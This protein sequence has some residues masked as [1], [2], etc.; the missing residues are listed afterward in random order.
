MPETDRT[1]Q[2]S[3][4]AYYDVHQLP[5]DGEAVQRKWLSVMADIEA[6]RFG[7]LPAPYAQSAQDSCRRIDVVQTTSDDAWCEHCAVFYDRCTE[8]V[9]I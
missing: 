5:V 9:T 4:D 8:K 2:D 1:C 7:G 6:E 3:G